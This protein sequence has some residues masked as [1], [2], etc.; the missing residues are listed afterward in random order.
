MKKV[1]QKIIAKI[2][3]SAYFNHNPF[4]QELQVESVEYWSKLGREQKIYNNL[5]LITI[6]NG[7]KIYDETIIYNSK[8]ESIIIGVNSHIRGE[9]LIQNNTGKIKVGNY[10]FIGVGSKLW[11][12]KSIT[13]GD[14]VFISHNVNIMD[15]NSHETDAHMRSQSFKKSLDNEV[16]IDFTGISVKEVVVEKNAWIGFNAIILKGVTI[17]EG[18]IVA[19]GSVVTRD[20]PP[21]TIVGGNPSRI[22]K[23]V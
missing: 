7:S 11:S 19:A 16:D 15:T 4:L 1:V 3:H 12:A 17:G 10:C 20:V 6:G 8:K 5:K 23:K 14:N 21:Y 22:I 18:A 2:I 9:L 13:I